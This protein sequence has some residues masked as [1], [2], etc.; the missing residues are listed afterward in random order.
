MGLVSLCGNEEHR[1]PLR[2]PES[3]AEE[4]QRKPEHFQPSSAEGRDQV[5]D[6]SEDPVSCEECGTSPAPH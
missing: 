3:A 5:G 1:E 4:S 2:F 6:K